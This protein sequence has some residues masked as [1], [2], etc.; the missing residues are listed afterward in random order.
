M[1]DRVEVALTQLRAELDVTR[2]RA[3]KLELVAKAARALA[4]EVYA[5]G[6]RSPKLAA[7]MGRLEAVKR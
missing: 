7:L 6:S 1:N 2:V 4:D 3:D 5:E